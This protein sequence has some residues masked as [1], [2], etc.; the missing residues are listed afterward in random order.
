MAAAVRRKSRREV[1]G[2][3]VCRCMPT[4]SEYFIPFAPFGTTASRAAAVGERLPP[5][6]REIPKTRKHPR[7]AKTAKLDERLAVARNE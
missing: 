5:L 4:L 1:W 3:G 6:N 2:L 7:T